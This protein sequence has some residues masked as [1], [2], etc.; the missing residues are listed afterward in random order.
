MHAS[1]RDICSNG[2]AVMATAHNVIQ[3][4]NAT[5][6]SPKKERKLSGGCH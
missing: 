4:S 6:E 1:V 5:W 2:V 3:R